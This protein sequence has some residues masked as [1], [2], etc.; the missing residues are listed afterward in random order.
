MI[1]SASGQSTTQVKRNEDAKME[2]SKF[3]KV[4]MSIFYGINPDSWLFR[5]ER[6]FQIHKLMEEE[7]MTVMVISFEAVALDQYRAKE[8]REPFSDWKALKMCLLQRF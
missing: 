1:E 6:Y 8:D 4:E 2:W 3:K 7:K 5:A